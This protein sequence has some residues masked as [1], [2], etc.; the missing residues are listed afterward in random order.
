MRRRRDQWV[1]ETAGLSDGAR[2]EVVRAVLRVVRPM[3]DR[4]Q[5]DVPWSGARGW[6][7]AVRDAAQVLS[8]ES[9]G[10]AC[11]GWRDARDA[12][13]W[14]AYE[15]LAPFVYSSDAWDARSVELVSVGDEGTSLT[16]RATGDLHERLLA[17]LR[18]LTSPGSP[19]LRPL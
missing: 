16:V 18:P 15:L 1:V 9:R 10:Y 17:S 7:S 8:P 14:E 11:T 13:Q 19:V 5:T 2:A 6:P 12:A 4:F 3:A